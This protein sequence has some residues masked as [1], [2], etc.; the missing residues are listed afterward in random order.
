M[1][2]RILVAAICLVAALA[3]GQT[4]TLQDTA[5][6]ASLAPVAAAGGGG[7]VVTIDAVSTNSFGTG[8]V[9]HTNVMTIGNNANRVLYFLAGAG[10]S[11]GS[12]NISTAPVATPGGA[13]T[14]IGVV[15]DT[16]FMVAHVYRLT[17]PAVGSI[18]VVSTWTTSQTTENCVLIS[19]YNVDQT[20]PEDTITKV[21]NTT[22]TAPTGAVTLTSSEMAIGVLATDSQLNV[23]V[24]TGTQRSEK[25]DIGTDITVSTASNTGTGSTSITWAQD[26]NGYALIVVPVN[27]AP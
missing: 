18:S 13:M 8:A 14:F 10:A 26:D 15:G 23:S 3:F 17:A 4:L 20:T 21:A 22:G 25:E 27:A 16:N 9:S 19:L 5:F 12:S 6:V 1:G 24:T 2:T 11:G 7:S